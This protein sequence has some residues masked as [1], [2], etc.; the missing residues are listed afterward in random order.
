M[1]FRLN[2]HRL[3]PDHRLS[4]GLGPSCPRHTTIVFS[5]PVPDRSVG[6]HGGGAG[7]VGER[8]RDRE[9]GREREGRK[10]GILQTSVLGGRSLGRAGLRRSTP[11]GGPHEA[12]GA[13]RG[14]PGPAG[15]VTTRGPQSPARVGAPRVPTPPKDRNSRWF[16]GTLRPHVPEDVPLGCHWCTTTGPRER[17]PR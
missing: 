11:G 12:R 4:T 8:G 3:G 16:T 6:L 9:R 5:V 13:P 17:R 1:C 14:S 7:G 2:G 15:R 10:R